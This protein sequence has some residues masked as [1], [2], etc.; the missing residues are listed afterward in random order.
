MIYSLSLFPFHFVA[1]DLYRYTNFSNS[2]LLTF[3]SVLFLNVQNA[4]R[5]RWMETHLKLHRRLNAF[6]HLPL[7]QGQ[8]IWKKDSKSER[9]QCP[10]QW[11]K[12]N[13]F[14]ETARILLLQGNTEVVVYCLE[15]W[16]ISLVPKVERDN[17]VSHVIS[18]Q[19][20]YSRIVCSTGESY[21]Y[22]SAIILW[23]L[24]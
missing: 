7:L 3:R 6:I 17:Q 15:P 23:P 5:N 2:T 18:L 11:L 13:W 12:S 22:R 19:R 1:F 21:V 14:P 9:G 8:K 16:L 20:T 4:C 24:A 10:D